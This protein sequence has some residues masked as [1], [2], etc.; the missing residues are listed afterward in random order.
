MRR[1]LLLN[2]LFLMSF[3]PAAL[4]G[5]AEGAVEMK[6]GE[7]LVEALLNNQSLRAGIKSVEADYYAVLAAMG[8]QRPQVGASVM[9]AWLT[10]QGDES[11]VATGNAALT[12]T[13][14][15]DLT[16]RYSLDE[17]QRILGYEISRA[18]FDNSLNSLI[19]TAEEAWWSAVLARENVRLQQEV[20][21][22]RAENHRVTLEKYNQ[23]LVPRLDV[24]RS[25]AQVVQAESLVK[26]A[27]TTWQNLL[28][29]LSYIAGGLDVAP[30]DEAL[31][32][33]AFDVTLDYEDALK[34]RPDV[35]AARLAVERAKLVKKLTGLGKSPTLDLG[36]QWTPW[37]EPE[38]AA[39]PQDGE[40]GASLSLNIPIFDG[41]Q[42]KYGTL[43]ADRL[44]QSAEAN[45]ESLHEQTRRDITVA[46]N[47]WRS[48]AAV[49]VDRKRQVERAEE[50]LRITEL[51]YAEGMGAQIDLINAQISYRVV[52]TEYLV[53]VRDMYVALVDL[54]KAMGDYSPDED[55]NWREAVRRYG[56]GNDVLGEVG[57]KTLRDSRVKSAAPGPAPAAGKAA[58]KT[59]EPETPGAGDFR[60]DGGVDTDAAAPRA[61]EPGLSDSGLSPEEE[62]AWEALLKKYDL[63]K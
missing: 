39:T 3:L 18:Q 30:V 38:T 22:Q 25:E 32:V 34:F 12:V 48:A 57:L 23:Q 40:A 51:M 21:R 52:R 4:A 28:A 19:A 54:R 27:E 7:Y 1:R 55:G 37:A 49:E 8:V 16:G 56:K 62:A 46:L 26:E 9:G 31:Q 17:R 50:E 59:P 6:L 5:A 42:T 14:R 35:R 45:L 44:V 10:G 24:V 63:K 13:H 43:N 11:N 60:L 47:N 33:P 29:N 36:V 2:I 61:Q 53:A 41:N 20:L 15:I 58:A